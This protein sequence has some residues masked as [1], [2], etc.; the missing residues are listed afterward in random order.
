MTVTEVEEY[1]DL[2][3]Q[4]EYENSLLKRRIEELDDAEA[5]SRKKIEEKYRE[6][7]NAK[8]AA[9]YQYALEL[10]ALKA[11]SD[12]WRRV[13]SSGDQTANGEIIDLLN[14]FLTDIG[15]DTA[16]ETVK[17]V[18]KILGDDAA[19]PPDENVEYEFDLDEAINPSGDLDLEQLC[20]ELG[21]YRG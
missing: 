9:L 12:K 7:E 19:Q 16:K 2:I 15:I 6:A 14:D 20:K 1:E 18:D 17:K 5:E 4:L 21:V 8:R 3:G 13:L 11:F 10:K